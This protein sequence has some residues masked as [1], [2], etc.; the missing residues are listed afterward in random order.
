MFL[1]VTEFLVR[2]CNLQGSSAQGAFPK[3]WNMPIVWRSHPVLKD[4]V[5]CRE[6]RAALFSRPVKSWLQSE[7]LRITCRL[8]IGQSGECQ[9]AG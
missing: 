6:P 3:D 2:P 7:R 4:T 5:S 1:G 9:A 8:L